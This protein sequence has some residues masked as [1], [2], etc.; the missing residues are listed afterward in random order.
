MLQ[1]RAGSPCPPLYR[2]P[3]WIWEVCNRRECAYSKKKKITLYKTRRYKS[4]GSVGSVYRL[5]VLQKN[6]FA[7]YCTNAQSFVR[8]IAR[9]YIASNAS[10]NVIMYFNRHR[11]R[12]ARASADPISWVSSHAVRLVL[13]AVVVARRNIARCNVKYNFFIICLQLTLIRNK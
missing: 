5:E 13:C 12:R 4:T 3:G 7:I 8:L 10:N 2:C 6:K 1:V 9:S 11:R